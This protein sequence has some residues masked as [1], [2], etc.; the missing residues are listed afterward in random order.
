MSEDIINVEEENI[1]DVVPI[2]E[3]TVIVNQGGTDNYERLNHKPQ[4]NGVELVGN[5]TS[6]DLG[7]QSTID[8]SHKLS[9]D[10]VQD[11]TT[12]K[13]YTATEQTKLDS[14]EAGAEVNTVTSVNSKN[15]AVV[16]DADDISDSTTTNKFVT[17]TDISNWDG[18][19]NALDSDQLAAVNSGIDSTKVGQIATNTSNISTINEKI[20][21]QASSSNQLADKNF[22]NSS[23][24]TNT[25]NFIGTFEDIPH[26]I[27][28]SGTI[29]NNDYA[30][31]VNSVIT[32]SG[33]DWATFADLDNYDKDL[34]TEFDYA[35]VVNGAKFDLYRFDIIDQEWNLRVSNT[36]KAS[37]TLNTAYNRYKAVVS[38]GTTTW[39]YEYTLNNSSFTASQWAA[40]NSGLT[41]ADKTKL[42]GIASGAEV[43]S[44]ASISAG[45]TAL[46]PDVNKNVNIPYATSSDA[47]L[48][49][50]TTSTGL[51]INASGIVYIQKA[52]NGYILAK[53]SAY[54]PIVPN[55]LD[56]AVKVGVTTNT[57]TLTSAEKGNAQTWL[58]VTD[59]IGD[60]YDNTQTYVVGDLVLYNGRLYKCNTA[61]TTAEEWNS[62]HW[63]A[64][65]VDDL[66][67]NIDTVLQNLISGGGVQ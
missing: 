19:Q 48:V 45:G 23:I 46:T 51:G 14:I 5:K 2:E 62:T 11:G 57:E 41:S 10:L 44:I 50:L 67:G 54:L 4:I 32:D 22:V 6:S 20:P 63:T 65:S 24:A 53:Q 18:K 49:K 8:N 21:A 58:G 3:E 7:L 35:W 59:L 34:L 16:L 38:G 30:F 36:D 12:N 61:I 13:V 27:A 1:E 31:V 55:N 33:N 26:L 37:V 56:Y 43:N 66:I 17:A 28:Y 52:T 9:A 60:V 15:G 39:A 64:T 25:A 42:D 47:G 29:T 40:I